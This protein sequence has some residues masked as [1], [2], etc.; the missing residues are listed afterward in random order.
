[1]NTDVNNNK[2]IKPHENV[3]QSKR[4]SFLPN[5]RRPSK[6]EIEKTD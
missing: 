5:I 2:I 6:V 4:E 1:M 3:I